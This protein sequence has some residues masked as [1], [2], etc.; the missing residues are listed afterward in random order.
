MSAFIPEPPTTQRI[1]N[2]DVLQGA[3]A[4]KLSSTTLP[5]LAKENKA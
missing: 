4:H 1:T 2:K 5:E 3:A